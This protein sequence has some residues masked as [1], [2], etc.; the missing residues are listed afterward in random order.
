MATPHRHEDEGFT[1]LEVVGAL[2]L[3]AVAAAGVAGLVAV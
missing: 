2:L 1:L 3:L